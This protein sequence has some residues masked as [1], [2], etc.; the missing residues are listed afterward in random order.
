MHIKLQVSISL[1]KKLIFDMND[2]Y[3][4]ETRDN[5]DMADDSV[6]AWW[7]GGGLFKYT[8]RNQSTGMYL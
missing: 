7:R 5:L 2:V 8:L 3:K 6:M 4:L 1:F